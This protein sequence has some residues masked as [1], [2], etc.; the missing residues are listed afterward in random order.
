MVQS[1]TPKWSDAEQAAQW[2]NEG[3]HL[4][5]P[6]SLGELGITRILTENFLVGGYRYTALADAVAQAKR[7]T[8]KA[9]RIAGELPEDAPLSFQSEM[10]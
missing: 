7:M 5:A 9:A 2:E 10:A 1:P 8:A 4:Q 3:G 6:L